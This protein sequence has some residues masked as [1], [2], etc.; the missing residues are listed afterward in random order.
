MLLEAW[1]LTHQDIKA[2]PSNMKSI[3]ATRLVHRQLFRCLSTG[4][5]TTRVSSRS[6][7]RSINNVIIL[8][9]QPTF[10]RT[11]ASRLH[12][13]QQ[14]DTRQAALHLLHHHSMRQCLRLSPMLVLLGSCH[15]ILSAALASTQQL[16]HH[17]AEDRVARD[18]S[19]RLAL[20]LH[21]ERICLQLILYS[22]PLVLRACLSRLHISMTV[23]AAPLSTPPSSRF[24]RFIVRQ[25]PTQARTNGELALQIVAFAA[26]QAWLLLLRGCL[27]LKIRLLRS[28]A[29]FILIHSL[30]FPHHRH[31]R[32]CSRTMLQAIFLP[33]HTLVVIPPLSSLLHK[34]LAPQRPTSPVQAKSASALLLKFWQVEAKVLRVVQLETQLGLQRH[35]KTHTRQGFQ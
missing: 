23:R 9:V 28:L 21:F 17:L 24:R 12:F 13:L 8:I 6:N 32:P 2:S 3:T 30:T 22:T 7:R 16:G 25:S 15:D 33:R 4:A 35:M 18:C 10:P 26:L 31:S 19:S 11:V 14:P 29:R 27:W 34:L 20:L 1:Q 5:T